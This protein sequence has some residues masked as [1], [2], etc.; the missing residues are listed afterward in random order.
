M[1]VCLV[2]LASGTARDVLADE[3]SKTWPPKLRCDEL[4]GLENTGVTCCGMVM[5]SRDNGTAEVGVGG[6][7]NTIL[8]GQDSGVVLPVRETRAEF[9]REF[10]GE[11]MEGVKDKGIGCRGSGEPF[12]EGGINEVDK[13]GVGEESNVFVV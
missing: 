5:V 10:A 3:G 9:S 1:C 2:L 13:E 8:E 6:D 7:V 4:A 12:R 11:C